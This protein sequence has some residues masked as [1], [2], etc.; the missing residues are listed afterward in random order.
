[1]LCRILHSKE[2]NS[3]RHDLQMFIDSYIYPILYLIY[4]HPNPRSQKEFLPNANPRVYPSTHTKEIRPNITS[5]QQFPPHQA[6]TT[7]RP[8]HAILKTLTPLLIKISCVPNPTP[9]I[10]PIP[11]PFSLPGYARPQLKAKP[12]PMTRIP[13]STSPKTNLQIS[14]ARVEGSES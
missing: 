9:F 4:L 11:T 1:V 3:D 13:T 6:G 2:R 5:K 7:Q 12:M 8:P 14:S 10:L